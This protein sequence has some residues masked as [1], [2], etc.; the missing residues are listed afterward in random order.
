MKTSVKILIVLSILL[1]FTKQAAAQTDVVIA[2]DLSKTMEHNDPEKYRFTGADIA[3][4]MFA[5]YPGTNRGGVVSFGDDASDVIKMEYLS[6]DQFAKYKPLLDRLGSETW[7]EL[8]KGLTRSKEMLGSSGRKTSIILISDGIVEGNPSARGVSAERAKE[9]AENELWNTII[10]SLRAARISVYTIGLFKDGQ[11]DE[12]TLTRIA[13][14]TG[15][16]YTHVQ[17]PEEFPQIYKRMLDDIDQ[18]SGVTE[19]TNGTSIILTP[20]DQ[21]LIVLGPT[22]FVLKSPNNLSYSTDKETI[23][24][25]V[26][27]KFFEYSNKTAILFL[28]RPDN[29]EL[30]GPFWNGRWLVE[31]LTGKGEATF[32]SK[33]RLIRDPSLPKRR[34]YF[35]NEYYPIQYQFVTE[36]GT[37]AES[38]LSKCAAEFILAPQGQ[39]TAKPRLEKLERNGNVFSSEVLLDNEGDY[40]FEIKITYQDGSVERWT[41]RDRFHVSKIPLLTLTSP[42]GPAYVGSK[43]TVEVQQSGVGTA[44]LLEAKGLVDSSMDLSLH[45][46]T[47]DPIPLAATTTS[48]GVFRSEEQEFAKA[49]DLEIQGVLNGKLLMQLPGPNGEVDLRPYKVKARV[50]KKLNV[51]N[52]ISA[53]VLTI[54][55]YG[56]GALSAAS[57]ILTI[58]GAV[59]RRPR[60]KEL[61]QA[62]LAGNQG[63]RT[64]NLDPQH[65][66]RPGRFLRWFRKRSATSIG[67]SASGADV[68]D[69]AL[70]KGGEKPVIEIS[71]KGHREYS[72][73][74]VG[75]LSVSWNGRPLEL[76]QPHPISANDVIDIPGVGTFNFVD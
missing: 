40:L 46:G 51:E 42:S 23:D 1:L 60:Y 10:P 68:I 48:T 58:L 67:G 55:Y 15:G 66:S 61:D 53:M 45:Y 33:V 14:Q 50:A 52:T 59:F 65:L 2:I 71:V 24:T 8:G 62:S 35:L 12:K 34:D 47:D 64:I 56:V 21:G 39:S 4:T 32:I 31:G 26:K 20:F 16:F 70:N 72:I 38:I 22:G 27:Q 3:L 18:P 30:N 36:P 54:G 6:A 43:F 75:D 29:L 76:N 25:P 37:D 74:R 7:T 5:F 19:L 69:G 63:T 13:E 73:T 49:G 57:A 44:G 17:T 28:G 11:G 41:Q 9:Q